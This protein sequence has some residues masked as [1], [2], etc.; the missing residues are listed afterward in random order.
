MTRPRIALLGNCQANTVGKLLRLLA[1]QFDV[2]RLEFGELPARFATKE[3][4]LREFGS[5]DLIFSQPFGPGFYPEV[6]GLILRERFRGKFYFYP[7]VDFNAFHPD[8]VYIRHTVQNRFLHSPIGD[9]HSAIAFLGYLQR[10]KLEQTLALF[11]AEIFERLGYFQYWKV[12]E[13][14]LFQQAHAIEFPLEGVYRSWVRR[15]PF[16]HTV[17]HPKLFVLADVVRTVLKQSGVTIASVNAEDYFPDELLYDAVWPVYPEVAESMGLQ[18]SYV[19]KGGARSEDLPPFLSL[20]EFVRAS[21]EIYR[22]ENPRVLECPRV[23]EWT[24][25]AGLMKDIRKYIS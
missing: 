2:V 19:F 5:F 1:P 9:Y 24:G 10:L 20:S 7:V 25:N 22:K 3:I 14:V 8:C 13:E 18:G 6:D 23:A 4:L 11:Q 17:N 21:W 15:C 16:M 12:S